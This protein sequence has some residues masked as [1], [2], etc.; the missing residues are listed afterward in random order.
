MCDVDV[1][2]AS[3]T[4]NGGE[5][6]IHV[7]PYSGRPSGTPSLTGLQ[8]AHGHRDDARLGLLAVEFELTDAEL[9]CAAY[10]LGS[11]NYVHSDGD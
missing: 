1:H 8:L 9:G 7:R 2:E 3:D 4:D 11:D 6:A 5:I 10:M